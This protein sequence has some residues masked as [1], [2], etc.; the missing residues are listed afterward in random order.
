MAQC[1]LGLGVFEWPAR[2]VVR[3]TTPSFPSLPAT[4][5]QSALRRG[6]ADTAALC[7]SALCDE[8]L[9]AASAQEFVAALCEQ[10]ALYAQRRADEAEGARRASLAVLE[11][12]PLVWSRRIGRSLVHVVGLWHRLL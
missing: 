4:P 2:G 11:V 3:L 12:R 9:L 8:V 10:A 6:A 5:H 7:A 1:L